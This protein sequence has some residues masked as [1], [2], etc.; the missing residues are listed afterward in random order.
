MHLL[1][2]VSPLWTACLRDG[3]LLLPEEQL[4]EA[5]AAAGL[6]NH[7]HRRRLAACMVVAMRNAS[8]GAMRLFMCT[9][10]H[11]AHR[12]CDKGFAAHAGACTQQGTHR[13]GS[14]SPACAAPAAAS[15]RASGRGVAAGGRER[16]GG[17]PPPPVGGPLRAFRSSPTTPTCYLSGIQAPLGSRRPRVATTKGEESATPRLPRGLTSCRR[18][19]AF[20]C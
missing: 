12:C 1:Q 6:H 10:R 16:A 3:N 9:C 19:L 2:S 15:C 20:P 14:Q 5:A 11:A 7:R 4:L 17:T 8:V 13:R 18:S